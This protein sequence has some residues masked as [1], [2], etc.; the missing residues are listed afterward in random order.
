MKVNIHCDNCDGDT[1]LNHELDSNSYEIKF[2][3]FC[4]SELDQDNIDLTEE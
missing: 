4:G 2:C 3:P 1:E